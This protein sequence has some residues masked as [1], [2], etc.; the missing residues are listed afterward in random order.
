MEINLYLKGWLRVIPEA[1][2]DLADCV[3]Q[4]L[5]GEVTRA[6][7][8]RA[9]SVWLPVVSGMRSLDLVEQVK[10]AALWL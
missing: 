7:L 9:E 2:E 10:K 6:V 3:M 8:G 4:I 5:G 1:V